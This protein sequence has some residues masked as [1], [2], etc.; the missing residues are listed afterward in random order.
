MT[1]LR[2]R[3][4]RSVNIKAKIQDK[5]CQGE[6]SRQCTGNEHQVQDLRHIEGLQK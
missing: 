5:K 2:S 1:R 4:R 3:I 6:N